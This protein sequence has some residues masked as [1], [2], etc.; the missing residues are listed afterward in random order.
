MEGEDRWWGRQCSTAKA[1][2][3][4]LKMSTPIKLGFNSRRSGEHQGAR[5]REREPQEHLCHRGAP[6]SS[7]AIWGRSV[8]EELGQAQRQG[9]TQWC[10]KEAKESR[11]DL[12]TR[13][14]WQRNS[15]YTH[16]EHCP[17][18]GPRLKQGRGG[19]ES[20]QRKRTF[21]GGSLA[22]FNARTR[23]EVTSHCK[24]SPIPCQGSRAREIEG[25]RR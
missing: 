10:V 4:L 14:D 5:D 20:L 11:G 21:G 15:G 1:P 19:K 6:R 24:V 2:A 7:M 23:W 18:S 25:D 16:G 12:Y 3:L 17:P 22:A 9:K 8:E 13:R